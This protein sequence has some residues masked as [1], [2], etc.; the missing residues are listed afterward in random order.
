MLDT[1]VENSSESNSSL[2]EVGGTLTGFLF[3]SSVVRDFP[4]MEI[5]AY[6]DGDGA[7]YTIGRRIQTLR[8]EK[9]SASVMLCIF[10]GTP[11]HLRIQEPFE[12]IRLGVDSADN[13]TLT[14]SQPY[15]VNL[16]NMHADLL[17]ASCAYTALSTEPATA[18]KC[19]SCG[20]TAYKAHKVYT[21][22]AMD[23]NSVLDICSINQAFFDTRTASR[24]VPQDSALLAIQLLQYPY[25]QD[26]STEP[27]TDNTIAVSMGPLK[28][29][30][31][32]FE[33]S[34]GDIQSHTFG[35]TGG[36]S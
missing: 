34:L 33:P 23:D 28:D 27:N 11:T 4:G 19:P 14:T 15:E 35:G 7:E 24:Y 13:E 2:N 8:Q 6:G 17:C 18:G 26:F 30:Y 21:R 20:G 16:K 32:R 10:N 29:I 5:A 31:I 1:L 12:G 22:S 9:L 25:Q 3:R 36:G